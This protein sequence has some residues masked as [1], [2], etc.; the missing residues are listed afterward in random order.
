MAE[1]CE[2]PIFKAFVEALN[3][4]LVPVNAPDN[5]DT[6]FTLNEPLIPTD[7]VM[8]CVLDTE[9]PNMLDPLE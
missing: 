5:V 7:P 2:F 8:D 3:V 4:A 9:L 6:P 1:F